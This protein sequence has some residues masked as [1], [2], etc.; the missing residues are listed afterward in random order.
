MQYLA[1]CLWLT[2]IYANILCVQFKLITTASV[3]DFTFMYISNY[4][5][6][7][8][9]YIVFLAQLCVY[10]LAVYTTSWLVGFIFPIWRLQYQFD[11]FLNYRNVNSYP[12]VNDVK[13]CM[14]CMDPFMVLWPLKF[15]LLVPTCSVKM[16]DSCA[17]CLSRIT[18]EY[19]GPIKGR[20]KDLQFRAFEWC[21]GIKLILHIQIYPL[22]WANL[23]KYLSVKFIFLKGCQIIINKIGW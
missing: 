20:N 21:Q 1:V 9:L 5:E 2:L 8:G 6:F 12:T 4:C 22:Q 10:T 13:L 15:H 23:K 11:R 19:G 18:L 14:F 16:K 3:Q 17:W 7:N